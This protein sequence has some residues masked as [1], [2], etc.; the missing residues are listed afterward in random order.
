MIN[1]SDNHN[2]TNV[3]IFHHTLFLHQ[4][5]LSRVE[6]T[7]ATSCPPSTLLKSCLSVSFCINHAAQSLKCPVHFTSYFYY[8]SLFVC[9]SRRRVILLHG[10]VV[11]ASLFK[12]HIQ[13]RFDFLAT[14]L[15]EVKAENTK[16][17]QYFPISLENNEKIPAVSGAAR[18][19]K[20]LAQCLIYTHS[21]SSLL[22]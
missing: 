7:T 11:T 16:A 3:L 15:P 17:G 4:F 21:H 18:S 20:P 22:R 19:N 14:V 10:R 8:N 13:R 6:A 12:L 1:E 9:F 5:R 2:I